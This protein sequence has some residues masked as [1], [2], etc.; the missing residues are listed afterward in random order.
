MNSI[1]D[2][3]I[4]PEMFNQVFKG[5]WKIQENA[6]QDKSGNRLYKVRCVNC[7]EEAIFQHGNLKTGHTR[8][9]KC[10]K[11]DVKGKIPEIKPETKTEIQDKLIK[12]L[13]SVEYPEN[14]IERAFVDIGLQKEVQDLREETKNLKIENRTKGIAINEKNESIRSMEEKIKDLEAALQIKESELH[15]QVMLNNSRNAQFIKKMEEVKIKE[16]TL[17]R[18]MERFNLKH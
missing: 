13:N 2:L 12:G 16:I 8:A 10:L 7:G 11:I 6:G 4:L 9:C 15:I 3:P 17:N 14:V 1:S 18:E 5:C